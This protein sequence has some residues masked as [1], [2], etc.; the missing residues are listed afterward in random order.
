MALGKRWKL[1]AVGC[2][3]LSTLTVLLIRPG[4]T[5]R[6]PVGGEEQQRATVLEGHRPPVQALAFDP[7]GSTLA[8]AA[9]YG[10]VPERAMEVALWDTATGTRLARRTEEPGG[11]GSLA[12]APG[13]QRLAAAWGRSLW[14]WETAQS[15]D[16]GRQFEQPTPVCALAFSDDRRL[17]AAADGANIVTVLDAADGRPRACCAGHAPFVFALAFAPG[18]SVLASG[19]GDGTI[20]LWDT[21]TGAERGAL[22][23]HAHGVAAV[24]FSPD[25]R[26]LASGDLCGAVKLWD[27]AALAER[28]T[29]KTVADEGSLNT[30]AAV[31]FAPDGR[32]LAVGVEQAVQLWDVASA[33]RLT[34]LAGHEGK[35]ICLA[36]SS[37]GTRLASGSWDRTVRLWDVARFRPQRP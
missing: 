21:A 19:G 23:G 24:A 7:D 18:G 29:L 17:L 30:I 28:G 4:C 31:A 5:G 10:N 12:F 35:V 20:R 26:M 8:S 33:S 37:D 14:L 13:G 34:S 36:Y 15:R 25:G 32:T 11:L 22:R 6:R 1:P 27:M 2:L 16:Q 3:A 9:Y